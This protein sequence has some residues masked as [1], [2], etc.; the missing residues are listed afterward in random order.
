MY[1]KKHEPLLTKPDFIKRLGFNFFLTTLILL[2]SLGL[3]I[4]GYYYFCHFSWIDSLLNASMIL[5]GMGPTSTIHDSNIW[6]KVFA[7]FYALFSG[8]GFISS[9]SILLAP[10]IHRFYHNFHIENA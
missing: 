4:L 3:G 2:S 7:S 8:I 6:G 5:S 1:E 9:V 10:I